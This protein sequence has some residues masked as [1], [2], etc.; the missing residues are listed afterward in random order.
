M[1]FAACRIRAPAWAAA[2]VLC[3]GF[4]VLEP[5]AIP[6]PHLVSFAGARR[7]VRWL[8]E[9][10]DGAPL[11]RAAV[12]GG[13]PDRG[14]EQLPRRVRVRRRCCCWSSPR[15][16]LVRPSWLPRARGAGRRSASPRSPRLATLANPYG[17][18]LC[19]RISTRTSRC[20]ASSRLRSCCRR[21]CR[22]IARSSPIWCWPARCCSRSRAGSRCPRAAVAAVF[23]TLGLM[24]L[25]ETPLVL[26]ATA[27]MVAHA[28][29]ALDRAGPRLPRDPDHR[30]SVPR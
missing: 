18:G 23:A 12:V 3:L 21:P 6:R 27:P 13:R 5:R 17:W 14:V 29:S 16:E 1:L 7:A 22:P 30:R 10:G 24:H 8:I 11:G 25:R 15:A 19:R 2:A 4:F 9:T 20:R 28:L 26:F